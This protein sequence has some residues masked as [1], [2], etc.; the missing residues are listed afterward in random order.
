MDYINQFGLT[1][2]TFFAIMNPISSLPVYLSLTDGYERSTAKAV[3]RKGLLIAFILV[4]IFSYT[5]RVIFEIFGITLPALRIAG[6]ILVFLIGFHMVQGYRSPMH[7]QPTTNYDE[8]TMA[9]LRES[10]MSIAISPLGTPLLAG[11]GTI[12]TA[13]ALSSNDSFIGTSVTVAAFF[14]LCVFTYFLF[15][16]AP[17]ITRLLGKDFMSVVTRMMGLMLAVIGTQMLIVG[18]KGAFPLLN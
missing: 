14:S 18:L 4:M 10:Q 13:M 12:S 6:G 11:P 3:A 9:H 17:K 8:K 1:F 5:G 2:M 7:Q 16:F 15:I